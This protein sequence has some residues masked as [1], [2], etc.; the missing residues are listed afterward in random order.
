LIF[1][2]QFQNSFLSGFR[3]VIDRHLRTSISLL[4]LRK[5]KGHGQLTAPA[6]ANDLNQSD[7]LIFR[8]A[9]SNNNK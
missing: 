3:R 9:H 4:G 5:Q 1:T 8:Q 6:A 7:Q 2:F